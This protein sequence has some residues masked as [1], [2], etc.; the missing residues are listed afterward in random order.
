MGR[1]KNSRSGKVRK[2]ESEKRKLKNQFERKKINKMAG[3]KE[4][5]ETQ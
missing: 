3:E 5:K 1:S 4:Q 2:E